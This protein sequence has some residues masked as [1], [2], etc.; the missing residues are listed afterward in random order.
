MLRVLAKSAL[1][2]GV[3]VL[4]ASPAQAWERLG[5]RWNV[6]V[7]GVAYTVGS[8]LS[9]DLG[10]R[11]AL[12][13]V[14][15]GYGVWGALSCSYMNWSMAGRTENRNWATADDEN[16]VVWYD[17]G[18]NE[19]SSVLGVASPFT[20]AGGQIIDCDTKYNGQDH[21][22]HAP[23]ASA[24]EAMFA[25]T[26]LQ[27]VV[28]VV[29]HEAGH[30]I[31]L[32]HTDVAGNTMLPVASSGIYDRSLGADDIAGGCELYPSGG[33]VPDPDQPPPPPGTVTFGNDCSAE[34]CAAALFCVND[35]RG[36]FCSR[37][38][39]DDTECG[40]GFFCAGL[41]QGNG[42]CARGTPP[43]RD[44]AGFGQPCGGELVCEAGLRCVVDA[45]SNQAYCTGPCLNGT[46]PSDYYCASVE[47][48]S[49]VCARGADDGTLPGQG[50][51]CG[52]GGLCARGLFC[53]N[54]RLSRDEIT[55]EVV[56]YCTAPCDAQG[57]C[58]TGY[59]CV[60]VPPDSTACQR[61][62]NA[63]E[64]AV[65]DECW[66]NPEGPPDASRNRPSCGE[67]LECTGYRFDP[68]DP[69]VLISKGTCTKNCT[70]DDCCPTGYACKGLTAVFA[71]CIAGGED[72][73]EW[74]CVAPPSNQ[75]DG[76]VDGEGNGADGGEGGC[77]SSPGAPAGSGALALGI[78]GLMGVRR[79]RRSVR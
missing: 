76:G 21:T 26:S 46:C 12:E 33:P 11:E 50:D 36:Q 19:G 47:D 10:D 32:G 9:D 22:W 34:G 3:C 55:N 45:D 67:G 74:A 52:D 35:G 30:C 69:N 8:V 56:P 63:G 17:E 29:A 2:S 61:I 53:L 60:D 72:D 57:M 51:S 64:R 7:E 48:G 43:R 79:R 20:S 31:G 49:D 28:G 13:G 27:D 70:P 39:A 54:D 25:G 41:T 75:V 78:L 71:Q 77:Q 23:S 40:D 68:R 65:G 66:V 59:R 14:Q 24:S 42:A 6:P 5:G 4:S 15:A 73:P 18:W 16:V 58:A 44:L 37:V 1:I 38:C 62:P